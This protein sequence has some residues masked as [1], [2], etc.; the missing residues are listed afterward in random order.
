MVAARYRLGEAIGTGGSSVVYE[1]LDEHTGRLV[2]LKILE[3]ASGFAATERERI[4]REARLAGAIRHES[5]V[6][7]FD[8]GPLDGGGAW[9]A[10][11]RLE[12]E[13]L[14]SRLAEC[15]WYP[16][17]EGFDIARKLLCALEAAHA[18]GV[19]H[20]DV[21]PSNV[22]LSDTASGTRL[23]L[24]DFGIS[25]TLGDPRSRV[26]EE[27]VV[28]GTLGYMAPEL[29]FGDEPTARSDVYSAAATIYEVLSGRPPHV[30][31]EG[32]VRGVMRALATSPEPLDAIRPAVPTE[33]AA[34]VMRALSKRPDDRPADCRAMLEACALERIQAA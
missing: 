2:A 33:L 9:L 32:D 12:G 23:T 29:L 4:F 10:M 13:T 15:F 21:N 16:L 8:A 22:I 24:I 17:E 25:R 18:H 1:A 19:V 34:G 5:I 7:V 14:R 11:E 6:E 31:D 3:P 26:T 20:R 27:N 30:I 28:V